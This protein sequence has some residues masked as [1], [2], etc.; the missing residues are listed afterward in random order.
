[1]LSITRPL[2]FKQNATRC[3]QS[4]RPNWC[5]RRHSGY[6]KSGQRWKLVCGTAKWHVRYEKSCCQIQWSTFRRQKWT[7][8][9]NYYSIKLNVNIKIG[10]HGMNESECFIYQ[11]TKFLL[12]M[13]IHTSEI[14]ILTNSD[15]ASAGPL[16]VIPCGP[17]HVLTN[18]FV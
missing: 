15:D 1:M 9:V 11:M 7:R 12:K 18:Q 14:E 4:G 3:L 5:R 10:K 8:W 6:N 16:Y 2:A 13:W 17:A